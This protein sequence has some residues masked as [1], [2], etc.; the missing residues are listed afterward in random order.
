MAASDQSWKKLNDF[1]L[2]AL[3]E[4]WADIFGCVVPS[5]ARRTYLIRAVAYHLQQ[6]SCQDL[7]SKTA[8]TLKKLAS[9]SDVSIDQWASLHFFH[10]KYA[11][12]RMAGRRNKI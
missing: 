9:R 5:S 1:S 7:T 2:K 10:S 8:A 4:L 6:E 11:P 12:R 3:R